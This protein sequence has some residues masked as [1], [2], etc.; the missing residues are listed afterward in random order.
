MTG[1]PEVASATQHS[2]R[3]MLEARD[4]HTSLLKQNLAAAQNRIK[5]QADKHKTDREFMVG[6]KVLVKLQP[7][8]QTSVV[9]RPYPKLSLKFY[10]PFTVLERIGKAAYKLELPEGSLIHPVFHVS[11]LKPYTPDFTPVFAELPTLVDLSQG[12]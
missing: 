7:Y 2:V 3:E 4:A 11:Q 1:V 12:I 8:A 10:G 5:T 9:N 6:D